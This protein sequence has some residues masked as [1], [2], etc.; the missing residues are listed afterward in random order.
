MEF[1]NGDRIKVI[2]KHGSYR[3]KY[4][5]ATGIVERYGSSHSS[6]SVRLDGIINE[7]SSYGIFYFKKN[8]LEKIINPSKE[9]L[10]EIINLDA[11]LLEIREI[12]CIT[13]YESK[14]LLNK[15]QEISMIYGYPIENVLGS[16]SSML[17]EGHSIDYTLNKIVNQNNEME[18]EIMRTGNIVELWSDIQKNK[19]SEDKEYKIETAIKSSTEIVE[20]EKLVSSIAHI[21]YQTDTADVFEQK[22]KSLLARVMNDNVYPYEVAMKIKD[23]EEWCK[24]SINGLTSLKKEI[25]TM[26][27][28]CET[29]EQEIAVLKT[30]DVINE[31]GKIE[32]Y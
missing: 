6:V 28:A 19:L 4:F 32:K 18:N 31:S 3:G 29:Y 17:M 15:A 11:V 7:S 2:D 21:K 24:D 8:E 23:A 16:I 20:I 12:V 9:V 13:E 5:G 10:K 25:L 1:I 27:G 14:E 30:Y 26:L 22:K